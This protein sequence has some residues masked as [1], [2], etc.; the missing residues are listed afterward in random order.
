MSQFPDGTPIPKLL[1]LSQADKEYLEIL[2][3]K[4]ENT[5]NVNFDLEKKREEYK[6]VHEAISQHL[7]ENN[8]DKVEDFEEFS[9]LLDVVA[10]LTTPEEAYAFGKT[11]KR[12][13]KDHDDAMHEF[14]LYMSKIT[15]YSKESKKYDIMMDTLSD[16]LMAAYLLIDRY[17]ELHAVMSVVTNPSELYYT[18][19][20]EGVKN[21][22]A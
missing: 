12:A 6:R 2:K 17:F 22:A 13:G 8:P 21:D 4:V 11:V 14:R 9:R 5:G 1:P 3:L 18:W 7:R 15:F 10:N 20:Y 16:A 19:G